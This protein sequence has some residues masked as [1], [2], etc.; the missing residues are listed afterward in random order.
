MPSA[1]DCKFPSLPHARFLAYRSEIEDALTQVFASGQFILGPQTRSFEM[2]FAAFLGIDHCVGV[3]N[4]TDAVELALRACGVG[5][6][7]A[8]ATVSWTATATVAAVERTGA[9]PLL[10]DIDP[11]SLTMDPESLARAI[12]DHR[13][14]SGRPELK[15]IVA[16]HLYGHPADMPAVFDIAHTHGLRV[17]EDCAQAHGAA[18]GDRLAG[19]WGDLAA[20]SF[21]PTKNLGAFGDAGAVVTADAALAD[22][23]RWLREYGWRERQISVFPGMNSRLDELQAAILRVLLKHLRIENGRRCELA[24]RYRAALAGASVQPAFC[25]S[26][27]RHVFHQYVVRTSE[28]DRLQAFLAE[29]GI[30][31]QVHYPLPVHRQPGYEGRL[32]CVPGGLLQTE[33]VARE[34]LSLPMSPHLDDAYIRRTLG[35]LAEWEESREVG[36]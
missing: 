1:P 24:R 31:T 30:A 6:G 14:R 17:I 26:G 12:L 33:R 28:R 20:F 13:S 8:V 19:T 4:G 15:A 29:R 21:Y 11:G 10:V 18:L 36:G 7:D 2:E 22:R 32:P 23:V 16:V 5:S 3:A 35:A 34:V 25:Q 27:A 9:T